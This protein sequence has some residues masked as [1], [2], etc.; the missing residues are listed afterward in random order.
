MLTK[1]AS[2]LVFISLQ[3][4]FCVPQKDYLHYHQL[5]NQTEQHLANEN[6]TVAQKLYD[7]TFQQFDY[8][9]AKKN[10]PKNLNKKVNILFLAMKKLD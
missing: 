4:S 2:L 6:F 5:I 8:V 9:F 10:H 7:S 1:F 3:Y